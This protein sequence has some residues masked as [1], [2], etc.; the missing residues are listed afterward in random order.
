MTSFLRLP[1]GHVGHIYFPA[2]P[3]EAS[4]TL[5]CFRPATIADCHSDRWGF[6]IC[7][8]LLPS[9]LLIQT[10]GTPERKDCKGNALS[11][12]RVL[13]VPLCPRGRDEFYG[14]R[15]RVKQVSAPDA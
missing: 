3:G 4:Q 6:E 11:V 12:R 2:G 8:R 15:F 1:F 10:P 14:R 5:S 13:S 7:T 9:S